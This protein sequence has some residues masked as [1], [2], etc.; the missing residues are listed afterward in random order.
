MAS[1]AWR[2]RKT[3][4][5]ALSAAPSIV[6]TPKSPP[7]S[8]VNS[9]ASW[10]A[11]RLVSPSSDPRTAKTLEEPEALTDFLRGGI[12][13][14]RPRRFIANCKWVVVCQLSVVSCQLSVV[15]CQL[16][17]ASCQLSVA[18]C[19]LPVVSCQL[20]VV[21]CQLSV[22]SCQL[23]VASCHLPVVSC[24]LSVVSCQLSVVS[25]Q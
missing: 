1:F 20:S 16:P 11:R 9:L 21:S 17:V 7:C 18:S 19:Q 22:A 13:L 10:L 3:A 5:S 15:S 8:G 14:E 6:S 12:A 23:P 2:M 25:C 24:Q 4:C